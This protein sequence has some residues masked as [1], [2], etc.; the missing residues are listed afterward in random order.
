M[1]AADNTAANEMGDIAQ[2]DVNTK[3]EDG[4]DVPIINPR[5]ERPLGL[6]VHVKGAYSAK[7]QEIMKRQ[8]KADEL[9]KR[10]QVARAV[11]AAN[12]DDDTVQAL[13][14]VTM[15]WTGMV[16]HG[17]AIPFS[18]AEALRVYEQYPLIRGQVLNAVIDVTNFIA[19]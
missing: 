7:F 12:E 11:A 14:E 19:G 18:K 2:L 5:T 10:N 1:N 13:A 3:S 9:R 8:R 4:I 15:G 17:K 6:V 16:E